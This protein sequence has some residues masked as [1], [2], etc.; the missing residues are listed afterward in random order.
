MKLILTAIALLTLT[1]C[2]TYDQ[3]RHERVKFYAW[4]ANALLNDED[5]E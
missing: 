4:F 1:S 3:D 5:E 2:A